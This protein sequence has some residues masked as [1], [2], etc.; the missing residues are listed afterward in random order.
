MKFASSTSQGGSVSLNTSE[1]AKFSLRNCVQQ[2]KNLIFIGKNKLKV[3]FEGGIRHE[4][5][6]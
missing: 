5:N 2:L 1:Q 6:R 3:D 4:V